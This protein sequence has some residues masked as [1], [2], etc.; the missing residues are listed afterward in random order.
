MVGLS[1]FLQ[2]VNDSHKLLSC[3]RDGD[4]VVLAFGALF[5]EISGE[6]R[7]PVTDKFRCVKKGVSQIT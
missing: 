3:M 5:G 4:V 1:G 7:L 6:G 2:S